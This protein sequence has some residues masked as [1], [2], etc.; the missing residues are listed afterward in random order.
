MFCFD[1]YFSVALLVSSFPSL[2]SRG[3]DSF[4]SQNSFFGVV[5]VVV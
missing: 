1:N 4:S 5:G 3:F 2:F